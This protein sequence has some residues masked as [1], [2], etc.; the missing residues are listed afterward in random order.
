MIEF[1]LFMLWVVVAAANITCA[2]ACFEEGRGF[3]GSVHTILSIVLIIMIL[4][5]IR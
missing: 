3:L 5:A 2:V 1:F 4:N